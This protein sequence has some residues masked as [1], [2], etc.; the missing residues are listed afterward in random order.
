VAAELRGSGKINMGT[1]V[2]GWLL[3]DAPAGF[4][5]AGQ[6]N[7]VPLLIGSNGREMTTLRG[8]LP[9]I[10]RTIRPIGS[11]SRRP[12]ARRRRGSKGSTR[13]RVTGR[14]TTPGRC[15]FRLGVHVQPLVSRPAPAAR[16]DTPA[17]LYQFTRYRQGQG[18]G[19]YHGLDISYIFGTRIPWL[20]AGARGRGPRGRSAALLAGLRRERQAIWRG[21]PAGMAGAR[22]SV[23]PYL[24]LGP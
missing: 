18:L 13:R 5:A 20:P 6:Q 1:V 9:R 23:R 2:D 24:D 4:F 15:L 21:E 19:A 3:P 16:A 10:E 22:R 11:G 8:V 14:S 12:P 17:Y 7:R